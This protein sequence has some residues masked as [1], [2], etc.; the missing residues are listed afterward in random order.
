MLSALFFYVLILVS[1]CFP[2]MLGVCLF[3]LF[4]CLILKWS[5]WGVRRVLGFS[6]YT[7]LTFVYFVYCLFRCLSLVS[8]FSSFSFVCEWSVSLVRV[9]GSFYVSRFSLKLPA[10]VVWIQLVPCSVLITPHVPPL[11]I[12]S[13]LVS[14]VYVAC[15]SVLSLLAHCHLSCSVLCCLL[16]VLCLFA[17]DRKSVV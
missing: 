7:Y 16:L 6:Q 10:S 8:S 14:P 17:R 12:P 11:W 1:V 3:S 2:V 15:C 13:L 9:S 4:S 5:V